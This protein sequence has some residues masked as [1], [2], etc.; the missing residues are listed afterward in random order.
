MSLRLGSLSAHLFGRHVADRAYNVP[1]MGLRLNADGFTVRTCCFGRIEFRQS[2][3]ENLE[4]AVFR[5]EDVVWLEVAMDDSGIVSGG[6]SAGQFHAVVQHLAQPH[7]AFTQAVAQ[8]LA[9][10]QLGHNVRRAVVLADVKDRNNV[11]MIQG[12]GGS[13]FL[14]KTAETVG[15]TG[16][17]LGSGAW[18]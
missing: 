13:G 9:L 17:V 7:R 14:L 11:G 15:I 3:V 1:R 8:G 10:Q 4:A 16:P 2:E 5:Q 6:Q 18:R 12:G